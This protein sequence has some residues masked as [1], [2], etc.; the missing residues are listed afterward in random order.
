MA[1]CKFSDVDDDDDY[2]VHTIQLNSLF[3]VRGAFRVSVK[4]VEHSGV[5]FVTKLCDVACDGRYL[6]IHIVDKDEEM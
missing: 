4:L 1:K 6:L 3:A 5:K 2:V